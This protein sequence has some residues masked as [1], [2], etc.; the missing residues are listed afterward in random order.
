MGLKVWRKVPGRILLLGLDIFT[1]MA[2]IYEGYNQGVMGT[3]SGT[4]GFIAMAQIGTGSKVTN[5]TK[6]G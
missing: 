1:F 2:L 6:Q 3:V 4:P 5:S